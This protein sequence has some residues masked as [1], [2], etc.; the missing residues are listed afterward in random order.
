MAPTG[1]AVMLLFLG[2]GVALLFCLDCLG[3]RN[4]QTNATLTWNTRGRRHLFTSS[5][6]KVIEQ[7]TFAFLTQQKDLVLVRFAQSIDG[8][9][10]LRSY[11][12]VRVM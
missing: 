7:V 2:A 10:Q 12:C 11:N 5:S 1:V 4:Y 3:I 6:D 9:W 8:C